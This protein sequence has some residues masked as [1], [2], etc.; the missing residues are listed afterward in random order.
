MSSTNT[1]E[2]GQA[3]HPW[4]ARVPT[5]TNCSLGEGPHNAM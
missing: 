3:L 4:L 1:I 5:K 2:L